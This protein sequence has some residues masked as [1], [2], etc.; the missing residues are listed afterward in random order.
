[1]FFVLVFQELVQETDLPKKQQILLSDQE[2]RIRLKL[3]KNLARALME[4]GDSND[5]FCI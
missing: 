5:G 4:E 3:S 2:K 1:M